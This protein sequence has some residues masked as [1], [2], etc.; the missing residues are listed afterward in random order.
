MLLLLGVGAALM[1]SFR[2]EP[3]GSSWCWRCSLRCSR[4]EC[5]RSGVYG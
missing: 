5:K 1:A 2:A 4:G 3:C